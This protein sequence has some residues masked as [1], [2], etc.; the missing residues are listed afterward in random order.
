MKTKILLKKWKILVSNI[1]YISERH[2]IL[3]VFFFFNNLSAK[4]LMTLQV[5]SCKTTERKKKKKAT[6]KY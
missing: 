3:S 2:R 4:T 6:A 5:H 1:N